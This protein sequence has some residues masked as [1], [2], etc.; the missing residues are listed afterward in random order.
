MAQQEQAQQEA[1]TAHASLAAPPDDIDAI[2]DAINHGGGVMTLQCLE[3]MHSHGS[4]GFAMPLLEP[5]GAGGPRPGH[6]QEPL[7]GGPQDH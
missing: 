6:E 3:P 7:V 1:P 2:I 4:E 5:P